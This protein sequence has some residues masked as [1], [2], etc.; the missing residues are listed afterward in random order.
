IGRR[1]HPRRRPKRCFHHFISHSAKKDGISPVEVLD[2]VTMQVFV[3]EHCTVITAPVQCD[4]DG[5]PKG[6]HY[7]RVPIAIRPPNELALSRR[8]SRSAA[9]A[10]QGGQLA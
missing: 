10:A 5:K 4:V 8:R 1:S 7:V 9:A 3:R 2:R 6:S